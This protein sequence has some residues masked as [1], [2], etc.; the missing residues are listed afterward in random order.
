[1]RVGEAFVV[2]PSVCWEASGQQVAM[3]S[4]SDGV[5]SIHHRAHYANPRAGFNLKTTIFGDEALTVGRIRR[6]HLGE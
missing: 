3:P 6:K 5:H 1:L 4:A 2:W